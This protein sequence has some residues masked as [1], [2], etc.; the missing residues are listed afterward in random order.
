MNEVFHIGREE[1]TN[2]SYALAGY[3]LRTDTV[4]VNVN[5]TTKVWTESKQDVET[6]N[7]ARK[8]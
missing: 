3:T 6:M 8:I 2:R 4:T 5:H 7:I 1:Y